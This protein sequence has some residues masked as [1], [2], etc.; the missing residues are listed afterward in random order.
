M[1]CNVRQNCA[2]I[3]KKFRGSRASHFKISSSRKN[4]RSLNFMVVQ[5]MK[6]PAADFALELR[7]GQSGVQPSAK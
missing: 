6:S 3:A 1:E 4:D 5:V 7:H 2:A